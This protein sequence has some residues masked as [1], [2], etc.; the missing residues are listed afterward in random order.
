M[1]CSACERFLFGLLIFAICLYS[2]FSFPQPPP[3]CNGHLFG[4]PSSSAQI[5]DCDHAYSWVPGP[6][7]VRHVFVEPQFQSPPFSGVFDREG[8]GILQVPKLWTFGKSFL[9]FGEKKDAAS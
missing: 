1:S 3:V 5:S 7:A 4:D 6:S 2:A 9:L 8:T